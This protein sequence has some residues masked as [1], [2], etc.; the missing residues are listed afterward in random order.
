MSYNTTS[1]TEKLN[2]TEEEVI[3]EQQT[4]DTVPL[5]NFI[6]AFYKNSYISPFTR[7]QFKEQLLPL[8][9]ANIK[10]KVKE[11]VEDVDDGLEFL[12]NVFSTKEKLAKQVIK[13]HLKKVPFVGGFKPANNFQ[14]ALG[15]PYPNL[16]PTVHTTIKIYTKKPYYRYASDGSI[17]SFCIKYN[18]TKANKIAEDHDFLKEM[19]IDKYKD[20]EKNVLRNLEEIEEK[21]VEA[22]IPTKS[23]KIVHLKHR[24][25]WQPVEVK[26]PAAPAKKA[27]AVATSY[28]SII[29]S[30]EAALD[31]HYE[32]LKPKKI[33]KLVKKPKTTKAPYSPISGPLLFNNE[34]KHNSDE[35]NENY[36][37]KREEFFGDATDHSKNLEVKPTSWR[38]FEQSTRAPTTADY[39]KV[40]PRFKSFSRNHAQQESKIS[41]TFA[42]PKTR[43]TTTRPPLPLASDSIAK[44]T[45]VDKVRATGKRG[46]VKFDPK[47]LNL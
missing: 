8:I 25:E 34:F 5:K 17:A 31:D 13:S 33:K 23:S 21:K 1:Y 32:K 4:S 44:S 40:N 12:A 37:F 22:T 27:K 11:F 28:T 39:A 10:Q 20:F 18:C 3:H 6:P 19:G 38:V 43:S 7:P 2:S 41:K 35:K 16:Q 36:L 9:G 15:Y 42:L 26:E 30:S 29:S 45:F 46:S 24:S 47:N 14:P